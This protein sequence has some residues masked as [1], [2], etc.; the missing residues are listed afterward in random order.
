MGMRSPARGGSAGPARRRGM[1]NLRRL[2]LA[3][4]VATAVLGSLGSTARAVPLG[5]VA[6][7]S[8]DEGSGGS[9]IDASGNG[10]VGTVA[11]ASW[12]TTGRF[13]GAL[14]F[15]GTNASVD[16]GALGTFYRTAFTLEA[17]VQKQSAT[18]NDVAVLGTWTA[19]ESGGPMIWVD[20]LATH[21]QLTMNQ[22]FSNYLDSG[23][24]PVAAV[25]QHL[26]VTFDGTQ[27]RFYIDGTEAASRTVSVGIGGSNSWRVGA[28]GSTPGGF[29]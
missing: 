16:L 17:W 20:H 26:A 15:N 12:T 28:Y 27:A 4:V 25:W 14:S 18:K 9:V 10:H 7:Y 23:Q 6:A 3:L 1:G 11:G 21:Y 8:F 29:F 13:G 5:L 24:S 2:V 22:G 19:N